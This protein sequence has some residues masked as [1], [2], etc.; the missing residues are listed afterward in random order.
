[1]VK[2][3]VLLL[4]SCNFFITVDTV[5]ISLTASVRNAS[6]F[7]HSFSVLLF[8][9]FKLAVCNLVLYASI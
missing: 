1:V 2:R 9:Y 3:N 5:G 4:F 6:I 8:I 7:I